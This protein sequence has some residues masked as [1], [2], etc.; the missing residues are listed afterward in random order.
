[1][2]LLFV[3]AMFALGN[4]TSSVPPPSSMLEASDTLMIVPTTTTVVLPTSAAETPTSSTMA[5]GTT[6][7]NTPDPTET[8]D[9][10]LYIA[11]GSACGAALLITFCLLLL[12]VIIWRRKLREISPKD[13]KSSVA[14]GRTEASNIILASLVED[15]EATESEEEKQRRKPILTSEFSACVKKKHQ[16]ADIEFEDEFDC[17]PTKHTSEYLAAKQKHNENKNRFENIFPY[18]FS[19]VVLKQLETTKTDDYIN[20]SFI[21][22]YNQENAY[23]AAQGPL[24]NTISDF[25]RM[26][27][28]RKLNAIIMLTET[29]E[30]GREKCIQY[31]PALMDTPWSLDGSLSITLKMQTQ[32]AAYRVKKIILESSADNSAPLSVTH[33]HFS[34]WPDHGVPADKTCLIQFIQR[35]RKDFPYYDSPPLVVHCSAG[36]GR[37]GT[38]IVLD[39]MLERMKVEDSL[40]IYAFICEM[41][42]KRGL[43]VQTEAQYSFIHDALDEFITCGD[44]SIAVT[45]IRVAIVNLSKQPEGSSETGYHT[46]FQLLDEVS[47]KQ[48]TVNCSEAEKEYNKGKNRYKEH[49]P[50]NINRVCLRPGGTK[51]ADYI[52]ASFLDGYKHRRNFIA[53]QAPLET[54]TSDFWRMVWEQK[55]RVLVMLCN[56][57]END[58]ITSHKYWPDGVDR[59]TTY[60]KFKV[61][62][63]DEN[64]GNQ[65]IV[66]K[67]EIGEDSP[68]MAPGAPDPVTVTQFHHTKWPERDTPPSSVSILE[69]I[70]SLLKIQM[71]T[72]NHAIVVMCNNG[73]GRTG[74]FTSIYSQVERIKAEQMA[75]IFQY[76][77]GIR[78]QRADMVLEESHFQFCHRVL[79][80]YLDSVDNYANFKDL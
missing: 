10:I 6:S 11:V 31:W 57:E 4:C 14:E 53:A 75:D 79:A 66:R 32:Y 29:I 54:T 73:V 13:N 67:F 70:N 43:M 8:Q 37:S 9:T 55:N 61:K 80:D 64:I 28:E 77:K 65:F 71:S 25:W 20:A 62:M 27:W 51:G 12:C 68:Y 60:G 22:G 2:L 72:G 17:L 38:F 36:V 21:N 56:L 23:I 41:R 44:T 78:L 50:Y 16:N 24:R 18:D 42:Q 30:A 69:M 15:D 59:T 48:T 3:V 40:D 5:P 52:N 19:R 49:I 46:Q 58:Q 74:T 7:P 63:I 47:H 76:V 39:S 34:A 1:M 45:N 35:V 26:V 33:F